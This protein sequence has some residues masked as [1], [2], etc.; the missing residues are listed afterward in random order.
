LFQSPC[1]PQ[2]SQQLLHQLKTRRYALLRPSEEGRETVLQARGKA[3][4]FFDLSFEEKKKS[5]L[6]TV[7]DDIFER[8]RNRGYVPHST[9]EYYK[10][11]VIDTPSNYPNNPEGIAEAYMKGIEYMHNVVKTSLNIVADG[12]SGEKWILSDTMNTMQEFLL[13]GSAISTL[14]YF[15]QTKPRWQ[16][17]GGT[18]ADAEEKGEERQYT[19]EKM[20]HDDIDVDFDSDHIAL[21]A[22]YDTG[23][24]TLILIGEIPGLQIWDPV[25]KQWLEMEKLGQLHDLVLIM[26]RKIELLVERGVPLKPTY[27]RVCIN[28][29][30]R[31]HSIL[32]FYDLLTS[33]DD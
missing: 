13:E 23:V 14:R 29:S 3:E 22:H 18:E 11:R 17:I 31:R 21:D 10:M 30:I 25:A 33:N 6:P 27:H 7:K 8:K 2:I 19:P 9:Q 24:F 1:P 5:E 4:E 15:D 16:E 28:K 12:E 26:G 32:F 20:K